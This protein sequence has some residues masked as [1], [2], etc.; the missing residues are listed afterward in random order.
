MG[1]WGTRRAG[2]GVRF[3]GATAMPGECPLLLSRRT[4]A[5][6]ARASRRGDQSVAV[7]VCVHVG[8]GGGGVEALIGGGR[9]AGR[10]ACRVRVHMGRTFLLCVKI[11]I[12]VLVLLRAPCMQSLIQK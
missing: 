1:Q 3:G 8:G 12:S 5:V 2:G 9:R 7:C 4:L 10:S 11:S 6:A